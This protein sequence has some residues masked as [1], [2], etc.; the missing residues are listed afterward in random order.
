MNTEKQSP[1]NMPVKVIVF[2]AKGTLGQELVREFSKN[3]HNVKAFDKDVLDVTSNELP[4]K[5]YDIKP[6]IIINASGYNSVD[7]A[8][9]NR[10][11]A[12]LAYEVNAAAPKTMAESAKE[13]EAVFINYSTD[14][15]FGGEKSGGYVESDIP[16]PISEYGKSKFLGEKNVQNA[17]GKYYIIRPSR[18]FG[19]PGI[20]SGKKS[21]VEVMLSKIDLTEVKVVNDERGSPTYATDLAHFTY[22]LVETNAP[23]GIYHGANDGSCSWYEWAQEIF[24]LAGK[25]P[26]LI[27]VSSAEYKNPAERPADSTLLNTKTALQRSWQ[28][29]LRE[30]FS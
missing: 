24:R 16:N 18:I 19:R 12:K 27:P 13:I 1:R 3:N 2:G 28:D 5:I 15:V 21:F 10:D 9:T 23:Y 11:E 7:L 14:Y 6:D 20:T 26:K 29:A 4:L 25:S 22:N 17:G 8:E 30:Y